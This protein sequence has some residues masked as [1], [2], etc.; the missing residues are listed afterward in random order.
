MLR[1][2]ADLMYGRQMPKADLSW[3]WEVAPFGEKSR[4]TRR[5]HQV[6]AWL[7]RRNA[8]TPAG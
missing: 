7:N 4:Q 8:A 6:C 1:D 2:E 5:V 3:K